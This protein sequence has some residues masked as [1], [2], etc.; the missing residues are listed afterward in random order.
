LFCGFISTC[1]DFISPI[2]KIEIAQEFHRDGNSIGVNKETSIDNHDDDDNQSDVYLVPK[3]RHLFPLSDSNSS[4]HLEPTHQ[5]PSIQQ[6]ID[7][8]GKFDFFVSRLH[9]DSDRWG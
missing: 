9:Q 8:K 2:Q 4:M 6:I 3:N 7:N 1:C 5:T